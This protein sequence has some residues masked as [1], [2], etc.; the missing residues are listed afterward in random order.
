MRA[1]PLSLRDASADDAYPTFCLGRLA[2][3]AIGPRRRSSRL[4]T[5]VSSPSRTVPRATL[6]GLRHPV[7]DQDAGHTDLH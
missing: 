1:A 2:T 4:T 6:L 5:E 3:E 7:P